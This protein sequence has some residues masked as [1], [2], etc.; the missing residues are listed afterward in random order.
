MEIEAKIDD[1][2]IKKIAKALS[3]FYT[4]KV[5]L[6][7]NS[8]GGEQVSDDLDMAGLGLVHEFGAN[9]NHPGGTP[10]F[11]NEFGMATFVKKDSFYGQ[12]LIN[13]GQVTKPHQINIPARPWLSFPI[14]RNGG[15]D[16]RKK[17]AQET[18]GYNGQFVDELLEVAE[19]PKEIALE[20]AKSLGIAAL[21]QIK[22]AFETEGFGEWQ[23]NAP[24]TIAQKGSAS[25]LIDTGRLRKSVTFEVEEND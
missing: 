10:Y 11:I 7:A 19:N 1:R 12:L 2:N 13:R 24:Q 3:K 23:P 20:I 5:G 9:I 17:F 18:G 6:L 21:E 8:G 25:P 15:A 14:T 22:E 4:V 16:L